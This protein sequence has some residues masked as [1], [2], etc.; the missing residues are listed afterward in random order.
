ML[1]SRT[2]PL[3]RQHIF[4]GAAG[5]PV[6]KNK[7]FFFN[8][9]EGQKQRNPAGTLL[10]VPTVAMKNGDFSGLRNAQGEPIVIYDP[11]TRQ[12]FPGNRIPSNRFDPVA[13]NVLRDVPDPNLTGGVTGGNN[14]TGTISTTNDKWR[15]VL[16]MDWNIGSNDKLDASWFIDNTRVNV[17]GFEEYTVKAA[18][19]VGVLGGF[20]F[21]FQTQVLHFQ[22]THTFS[23]SPFHGCCFRVPPSAYLSF[24]SPHRS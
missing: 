24:W 9:F 4:G 23:P 13:V 20:G 6:I 8:N 3:D 17:P 22:E 19:P 2:K 11:T 7:L 12:P 14:L 5:G 18:S 15:N 21:N 1:F 10:T 16:K